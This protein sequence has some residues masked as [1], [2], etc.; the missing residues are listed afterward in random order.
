MRCWLLVRTAT[1]SLLYDSGPCHRL[2]S[3]AGHRVLVPLL[4]A[5]GERL[6]TVVLSHRDSDHT[7]GA[8]AVLA[9]QAEAELRSSVEA[10]HPL[11]QLRPVRRCLAGQHW[12][13]DGVRFEI[14]HPGEADYA[15]FT[16]PNAVSC[17]LRI[18]NGRA[19]ALLAGDIERLQ[20]AALAARTPALQAELLLV[21][22]HGSKTSS[23]PALLDAV[24]P[25]IA[26]A[27]AIRPRR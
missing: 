13:W 18:G 6:D 14:L 7:G 21:P 2:E 3:D 24:Q 11:Q 4:R 16:K 17:V 9:M 23:S 12:S 26:T 10:G 20:E 19:T 8:P 25:R 27:S 1:H 5:L 22:H 15:G